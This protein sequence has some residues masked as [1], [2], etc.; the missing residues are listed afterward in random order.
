MYSMPCASKASAGGVHQIVDERL[1]VV[2]QV[3][4]VNGDGDFLAARAAEGGVDV[5]ERV[6]GRVGDGMQAL[7]DLNADVAG[8][9]LARLLAVLN[10]QLAL[11]NALRNAH[12]HE[13]IR[14][15]D[16]GR[17]HFTDGDPRPVGLGKSLPLDLKFPA[18][19]GRD[20]R[21]L[22]DLW[23]P[24]ALFPNTHVQ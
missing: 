14:A 13:G 15:D 24:V 21:N 8:P 12:D 18:G 17:G 23:P 22:R 9:G 1:D 5:A 11:G 6:D 3:D 16:D 20:G 10:H 2:V 19:D 7:G 4:L